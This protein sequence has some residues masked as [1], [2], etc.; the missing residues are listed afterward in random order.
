[1]KCALLAAV[2]AVLLTAWVPS[3]LAQAQP[4]PPKGLQVL[5][6]TFEIPTQRVTVQLHN[7]SDKTIVAYVL[8]TVG[9]DAQGNK[10]GE[11][12]RIF[13]YI[14]PEP[15]PGRVHFI[16][17]GRIATADYTKP[18]PPDPRIL[19]FYP[20]SKASFDE[21]ATKASALD[22]M[23]SVQVSVSEVVYEDRTYEGNSTTY[24]GDIF[25]GRLR[26]L[27]IAR[28]VLKSTLKDYPATQEER[29]EAMRFLRSLGFNPPEEPRT[30]QHWEA[31]RAEVQRD[32]EWWEIQSKAQ[33]ATK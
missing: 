30:E 21:A 24:I 26:K 4:S 29:R 9:L 7:A 10:V 6:A 23:A 19:K 5:S 33:G 15:N 28:Q 12:Q 18:E 1:M 16:P 14:G 32:A 27:Y 11:F 3:L 31:I 17:S 22:A 25:D 13:D 2:G 8:E 20:E